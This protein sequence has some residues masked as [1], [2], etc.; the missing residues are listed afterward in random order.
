[1]PIE[2]R[3]EV[4]WCVSIDL[5]RAHGGLAQSGVDASTECYGTP[6][7]GLGRMIMTE[8][9]SH[10]WAWRSSGSG[11]CYVS[12]TTHRCFYLAPPLFPIHSQDITVAGRLWR[13]VLWLY[14]RRSCVY[15]GVVLRCC[16]GTLSPIPVMLSSLFIQ[17]HA[18]CFSTALPRLREL[19]TAQHMQRLGDKLGESLEGDTVISQALGLFAFATR[20]GPT[21]PSINYNNDSNPASPKNTKPAPPKKRQQNSAMELNPVQNRRRISASPQSSTPPPYPH[22]YH[23]CA[24]TSHPAKPPQIT[25]RPLY[26][27]TLLN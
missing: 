9:R 8:S 17:S 3:E 25:T 18:T 7:P 11:L 15:G 12:I 21:D 22:R 23:T 19:P 20:Y 27:Q 24:G 10:R 14:G 26:P 6:G 13:D 4:V 5:G 1:M 16:S 2:A